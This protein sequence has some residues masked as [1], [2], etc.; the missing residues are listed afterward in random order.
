M[1]SLKTKAYVLKDAK[2]PNKE[3]FYSNTFKK[4]VAD[5]RFYHD[6]IY[7]TTVMYN[8]NDG[9]VYCGLTAYDNDLLWTFDPETK[10]FRSCGYQK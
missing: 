5:E 9:L 1:P 10:E 8:P 6:L 2:I 4:W 7:F 3:L